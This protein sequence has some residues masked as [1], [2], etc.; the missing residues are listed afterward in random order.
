MGSWYF[1]AF[2][3]FM[4]FWSLLL[5]RSSCTNMYEAKNGRFWFGFACFM[6][7]GLALIVNVG[8]MIFRTPTQPHQ[9]E[10]QTQ[11]VQP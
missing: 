6:L 5:M 9:T 10:Q 1:L 11:Q 4:M 2:G 8:M 3:L 7:M